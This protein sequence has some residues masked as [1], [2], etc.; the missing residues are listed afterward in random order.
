MSEPILNPQYPGFPEKSL[1]RHFRNTLL[2]FKKVVQSSKNIDEL[3]SEMERFLSASR[4]VEWPHHT[5]GVFHKDEAEKAV[6][7]VV[8]EFRRYTK[9]LKL[10]KPHSHQDLL[11]SLLIVEKM[12]GRLKDD[13]L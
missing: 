2:Q 11:D 13:E 9:D 3:N 6:D 10:H 4:K 1:V 7:K 5:S 12:I 8:A